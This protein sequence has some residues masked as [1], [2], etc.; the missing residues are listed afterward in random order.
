MLV[1]DRVHKSFG[2]H[3]AVRGVSFELPRGQVVGLLGPNGAGKTT[4]I[5]MI[6]GFLP[7]DQ[8]RVLVNGHD[9][10]DD[11]AAARRSIGYLPE[12][13]PLYPEM[14]VRGYLEYRGRLFAM[15]RRERRIAVDRVLTRCWLAD[16]AD[17]RIGHLSKGYKQRVGLA[18]AL[19]HD[20]P[21]VILDEPSNG[22]DPTQI[23]ETRRLIAE[24]GQTHTLLISSHILPEVERTCTRVVIIIR[25]LVRADGTPADL[26]SRNTGPARITLEV[27]TTDDTLLRGVFASLPGVSFGSAAPAGDG[28]SAVTLLQQS[29]TDMREAIAAACAARG[30]PL[31]A[32]ARER[33]TLEGV[34]LSLL[35]SGEAREASA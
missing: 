32:L 35:E 2:K 1:V 22:L 13:A 24:L 3:A 29:G 14:S 15:P 31:R 7:P 17:R 30:L 11:S 12:S 28:W 16:V 9:T 19:L 26:I 27:R 20:P 5:R 6:T 23:S 4:T 8:G 10:L 21:V 25:G 33:S 18:A 34:F